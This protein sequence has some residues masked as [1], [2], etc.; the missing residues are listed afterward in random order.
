MCG[1]LITCNDEAV[2]WRLFH[3]GLRLLLQAANPACSASHT[4]A[5]E[6]VMCGVTGLVVHT[7]LHQHASC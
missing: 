3:H 1:A 2:H 7:A 5:H 6:L 4:A